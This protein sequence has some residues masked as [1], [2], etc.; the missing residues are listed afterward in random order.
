M[1]LIWLEASS[2]R[3]VMTMQGNS[4]FSY[5]HFW[6]RGIYGVSR[7]WLNS[8]L[9]ENIASLRLRNFTRSLQLEGRPLPKILLVKYEL[10]SEKLH[11][12]NYILHLEID[13]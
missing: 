8:C 9:P 12:G 6:E 5:R 10:W 13:E 2:S 4:N 11:L 1:G 3:V 7:Y